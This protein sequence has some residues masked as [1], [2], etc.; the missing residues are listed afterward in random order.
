LVDV[1]TAFEKVDQALNRYACAP[2][3]RR[4]A[5]ALRASPRRF[6]QPVFLLG[7][8]KLRISGTKQPEK[9]SL[10][11]HLQQRLRGVA[12]RAV[13]LLPALHHP[14]DTAIILLNTMRRLVRA[15]AQRHL[16][17]KL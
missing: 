17:R 9:T 13:P 14:V 10:P 3:A 8:H 12:Q 11:H 16:G 15:L 6:I 2:E 5:H 1:L 7:S 4:T